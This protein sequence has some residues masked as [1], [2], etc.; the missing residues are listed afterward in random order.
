MKF[1]YGNAIKQE[2]EACQPRRVAVAYLGWDW[3]KYLTA[4]EQLESIVISPTLGTNPHAVNQLV[5]R[6]GRDGRS[7]WERVHF[8]DNLHTKLYLGDTSCVL[9][10]ANLTANGL[11]GDRL[12]EAAVT[13]RDISLL[14][15][16]G[17]FFED[18][19][20][21]QAIHCYPTQESKVRRL[22]QLVLEHEKSKQA[23]QPKLPSIQAL[24]DPFPKFHVSWYT[25]E[26][27]ELNE[28][29]VDSVNFDIADYLHFHSE[30][31]IEAGQWVLTWRLSEKDEMNRRVQ[32]CWMYIDHVRNDAVDL[33]DDPDY[34]YTKVAMQW[35]R[36]DE[37]WTSLLATAPF[38][39]SEPRFA[40]AMAS[41]LKEDRNVREGMVQ[42][43][44]SGP[45]RLNIA[46]E[47]VDSFV[48]AIQRELSE[49]H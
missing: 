13:T 16:A 21:R 30:D 49:G 37:E 24:V 19:V 29:G 25:P 23:T 45:W 39:A 8:L 4:P 26:G 34:E 3:S 6:L 10:S 14:T 43:H 38:S 18:E 33:S 32:P 46:S 41:V 31:D 28:E 5:E 11:D 9:G 20:L 36:T 1:V 47:K 15:S 42:D 17:K 22:N 7:G 48:R 2:I 12:I 44:Q 40:A 27:P 35:V